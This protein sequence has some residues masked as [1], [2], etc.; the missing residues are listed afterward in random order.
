MLRREEAPNNLFWTGFL[1]GAAIGGVLG[2]LLASELGKRALA[3]VEEAAKDLQ[4]RYNGRAT[5]PPESSDGSEA[6]AAAPEASA[7]EAPR[8]G[9][10]QDP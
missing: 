3:H 9:A 10:G 6:E 2:G 5:T 8:G 1:A 4:G 7:T